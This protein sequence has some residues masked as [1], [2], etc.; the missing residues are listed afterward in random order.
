MGFLGGSVGSI[1]VWTHLVYLSC[2]APLPL[3]SS[4]ALKLVFF[5]LD[6]GGVLGLELP[7]G[8]WAGLAA[9][10]WPA[11]LGRL[12]GLA[13]GALLAPLKPSTSLYNSL[14][15]LRHTHVQV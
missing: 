9:L 10:G 13:K 4:T 12:L 8:G 7:L 3:A 1:G 11:G 5:L 15:I 6:L 2:C 14:S